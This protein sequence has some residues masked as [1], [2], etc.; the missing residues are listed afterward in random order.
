MSFDIAKRASESVIGIWHSH[1]ENQMLRRTRNVSGPAC[2]TTAQERSEP[3]SLSTAK[4]KSETSHRITALVEIDPEELSTAGSE[5]ES[6]SPT[7]ATTV[8]DLHVERQHHT[9]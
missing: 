7:T 2:Q 4:H 1:R 8:N 9:Q 3:Y 6:I 5:S